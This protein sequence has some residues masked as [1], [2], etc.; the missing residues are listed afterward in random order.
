[1]SM[2]LAQLSAAFLGIS[3]YLIVS[4]IRNFC[5]RGCRV[6]WLPLTNHCEWGFCECSADY[7]FNR[8][9]GRCDDTADF[10][11]KKY[12][13]RSLP[14]RPLDFDPFIG[15]F[16]DRECLEL[17]NNLFC[18]GKVK[19]ENGMDKCECRKD[20]QWNKETGECQVCTVR[21]T[22]CSDTT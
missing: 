4:L 1:M 10:A 9:Y 11:S 16:F 17:D 14:D 18:S 5:Y 6:K 15:C 8:R 12:D 3:F 22:L 13:R 19:M 7:R 20:M 2:S 21:Q